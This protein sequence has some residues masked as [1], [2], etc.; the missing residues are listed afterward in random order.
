MNTANAARPRPISGPFLVITA[1]FVTALIVSNV[2]SVKLIDFFGWEI[3]AGTIIF[4]V[5]YIFGDVLTEVYGYGRARQVIWLGFLCNL[6]F[7]LVIA[8]AQRLPASENFEGQAAYETILGY[9]PRLLLASFAAYLVGEFANAFV[10]ARLKVAT[11][12]RFLWLR[13]I[14]STLVGQGLDSVIFVT[15][16]FAG[17]YDRAV[18]LEIMRNNWLLKVAYEAAATPLTYLIVG[19]LKAIEGIDPF[20]RDGTSWN[21]FAIWRTAPE[22]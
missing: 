18:V 19:R 15:I 8:L 10:L 20:D 6:C 21:P 17:T 3:D 9:T 11:A 7:V 5:T 14:S 12:G 22:R 13:T 2:I 16:A 4:P 1:A